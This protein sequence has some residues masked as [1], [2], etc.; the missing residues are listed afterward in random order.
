MSSEQAA[1]MGRVAVLMGGDSAE[2]EISLISG[3]AVFE[4]LQRRGVDAVAVDTAEVPLSDLAGFDRAF[5]ALHGRGGE[6]GVIQGALE[7][8][9][10]PYTGSGVLG[11]A[12]GMDK[13]RTKLLWRGADLPVPPGALLRPETNQQ[14]LVGSVGLPLMI[15]P[16][17][18][19][20]SIGMAR[21]ER[22]EDLETAR[23]EAARFD[24]LVLA[25]RWIDGQEYTVAILGE[26]ALP[27]IR[28]ETPRGFYDFEAKYRSGDTCYHCPAGLDEAEEQQIRQLALD[29]FRVAGASGW[30]RV[31]LM[32]DRQG[33]FW[34]LEINTIPGMTDH[35]LVPMAAKAVGI[36][37][38]E[39]CWRILLD[40]RRREVVRP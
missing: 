19:G 8:L 12:I 34:L 29:A 32:R 28:L 2:R 30:G 18:E 20:S 22:L 14:A 10:V 31:D 16:A 36:D 35:S 25:E 27:A 1:A 21:V 9:G 39:L 17:H 23:A 5:I 33:R 24:D 7:A 6:D 26:E 3:R 11:C 40:S 4:A 13:W 38:D 37:F 15:K